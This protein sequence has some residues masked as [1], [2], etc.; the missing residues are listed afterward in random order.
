MA[1]VVVVL[2]V[3]FVSYATSLRAYL[4]QRAQISDLETQIAQ[5]QRAIDELRQERRRWNDEAYVQA[6]ARERFG[7]VMPGEIGFRVIG[8]DGQP[9]DTGSELTDPASLGDDPDAEWWSTT[10]G[11]IRGA[12]AEKPASGPAKRLGPPVKRDRDGGR[13]DGG[14]A[15]DGRAGDGRA[16]GGRGR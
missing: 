3:L 1:I 11:S 14:R 9:I 2:A 13:A 4:N 12:G 16:D 15:N 5:D 7:W 10:W 8:E 6:R